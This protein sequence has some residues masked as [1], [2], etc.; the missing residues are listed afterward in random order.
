MCCISLGNLGLPARVRLTERT[1]SCTNTAAR[2]STSSS[3]PQAWSACTPTRSVDI[4]YLSGSGA[5]DFS[6]PILYIAQSI[7]NELTFPTRR[8]HATTQG[9]WEAVT[10]EI[11]GLPGLKITS[12]EA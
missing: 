5:A 9:G 7:A 10:I 2:G 11:K 6:S 4:T 8:A 12:T 1:T 3:T